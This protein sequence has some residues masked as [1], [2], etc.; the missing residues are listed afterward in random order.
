[1][2]IR[3]RIKMRRLFKAIWRLLRTVVLVNLAIF[4]TVGLICWLVD[5]RTLYQYGMG[6]TLVGTAALVLGAFSIAGSWQGRGSF[7]E[8][9]A[10]LAGAERAHERAIRESKGTS[11][12]YAF[13][14]RMCAIGFLPIAVGI[15]LQTV[16]AG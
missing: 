8:Q 13:L 7:G 12:N 6:L 2:G 14:G 9:Y 5:W 1:M 10:A 3:T 15:L 11:S 16:F 4:V